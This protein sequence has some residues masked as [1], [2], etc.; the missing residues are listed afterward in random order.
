[1]CNNIEYSTIHKC[2]HYTYMYY[3]LATPEVVV[4]DISDLPSVS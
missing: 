3:M 2:L 4:S 1:M